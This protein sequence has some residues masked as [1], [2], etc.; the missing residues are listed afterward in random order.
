MGKHA[1]IT[2]CA[3][4]IYCLAADETGT[5]RCASNPVPGDF[6]TESQFY[7]KLEIIEFNRTHQLPY[8]GICTDA[9]PSAL[10]L[11]DIDPNPAHGEQFVIDYHARCG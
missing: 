11:R 8:N 5:R 4:S 1:L 7:D 9:Y 10:H 2:K 3:K 6:L